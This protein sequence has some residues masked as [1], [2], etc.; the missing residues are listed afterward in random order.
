MNDRI[1]LFCQ[2]DRHLENTL[3]QAHAIN[4]FGDAVTFD[5]EE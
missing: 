2:R 1:K 4:V 5:E 3:I